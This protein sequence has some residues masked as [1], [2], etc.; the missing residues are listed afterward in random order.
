MMKY[1]KC[2]KCGE[3]KDLSGYQRRSDS[4]DGYRNQC[5]VC[6]TEYLDEWRKENREYLLKQNREYNAVNK[7]KRAAYSAENREKDNK[8]QRNRRK[9][10]LCYRIKRNLR[11]RVWG[12]LKGI[13]KSTPTLELIGCDIKEF[14]KHIERQFVEGMSWDNYGEWEVDHIRPCAS[15]DLTD[16]EEQSVCFHYSNTQ[17][18][19][20]TDNRAKSAQW[21]AV[22]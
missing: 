6:H 9:A 2:T 20:R 13:N 14:R 5:K 17:P 15:F 19:W 7:E 10:D 8:Y 1:K 18:L 3:L 11:I 4:K 21:K 22:I 12:A 16:T